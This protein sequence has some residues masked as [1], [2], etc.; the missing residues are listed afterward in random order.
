M[1]K[2]LAFL[3]AVAAAAVP[4]MVVAQAA[5]KPVPL[6]RVVAVVGSDPIMESEVTQAIISRQQ[7]DPNFLLPADSADWASFQLNLINGLID[8]R[9]LLQKAKELKIDLPDSVLA[10]TI[11]AQIRQTRARFPTEAQY[12]AE[13]AKAGLGTPDE[14]RTF[15]IDQLRTAQLQQAAA[16]KLKQDGQILPVSV[17]EREVQQAFDAMK[18]NL[19]KRP[20]T[21]T[22]HQIVINPQASAKAKAAAYAKA[23]SLRAEIVAGGDF[24]RI[25]KRESMDSTTREVGGDL[26]WNRRGGGLVPSFERMLFSVEPGQISPV[27]E[28][29]FGYHILRVDRVNGPE[30]KA[31]HILIRPVIDS[32][33]IARTA[34]LADSV[35]TMWERGVPFDTLA[36]K[37]HD[38][39]SR[40]ETSIL[41]PYPFDSLPQT[42]QDAFAG[43]KADDVVV[44]R[45]ANAQTPN[46]P[47]FVVARIESYQPGGS[48][49]LS[50]VRSR[51]RDN[52][53]QSA[54]IRHYLDGLRKTEFVEIMHDALLPP[55]GWKPGG[56]PAP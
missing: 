33:D 49:T 4:R 20:A 52:L 30:R 50:D 56:G 28:T 22:W 18:G 24:A 34:R 40:E 44:F 17:S 37:Y 38:Y 6:D 16:A 36:A 55:A 27:F 3:L 42:Y 5:A 26:G 46:V 32:A 39:A 7:Q 13:L 21:F 19:P 25:A 53:E 41:T 29:P 23:E 15:L 45:I 35:K 1:K 11:D 2:S 48:M 54:A 9:L 14:Y 8:E 12:R 51:L 10:P 43:L 47:K 31:R